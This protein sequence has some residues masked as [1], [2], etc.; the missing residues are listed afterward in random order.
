MTDKLQQLL[1]RL[2]P[3][4]QGE[5]EAFAAFLLTRR[6]LAHHILLTGD[7]AIPELMELVMRGG[8]FD[9]LEDEGQNGYTL[10]DG[11]APA[12]PPGS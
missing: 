11:E 12:W 5:L 7:M 2:T 1:E 10:M 9:W 3:Q 6:S 4:E 8:A